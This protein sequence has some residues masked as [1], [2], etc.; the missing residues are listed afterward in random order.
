MLFREGVGRFEGG[1]PSLLALWM[2][3]VGAFSSTCLDEDAERRNGKIDIHLRW[4]GADQ[5]PVVLIE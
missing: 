4:C 2:M 5:G 3:G 1:K